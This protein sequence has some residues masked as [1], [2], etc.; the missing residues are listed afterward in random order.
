M[1]PKHTNNTRFATTSHLSMSCGP[2]PGR[3]P[4]FIKAVY[5]VGLHRPHVERHHSCARGGR[6]PGDG[7]C[8][9]RG[10]GSSPG[11][12]GQTATKPVTVPTFIEGCNAVE[13]R[14]PR[15]VFQQRAAQRRGGGH[16]L[17]RHDVH[18]LYRR[19]AKHPPQAHGG[20]VR[21]RG[22]RPH[23]R[24]RH[25]GDRR[26][27]ALHHQSRLRTRPTRSAWRWSFCKAKS[28]AP[29]IWAWT[30]SCCIPGA[31]TDKDVEY[32]IDR[33]AEGLDEVLSVNGRRQHRPGDDGGQRHRDRAHL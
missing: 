8:G 21:A 33:I 12:S 6:E 23:E 28:S 31:Y 13:D 14:I 9:D 20:A 27:R 15:F 10:R 5:H 26:A 18:D 30:T 24:A 25:R 16:Q 2:A 17:R 32:G 4:H 3:R 11:A 1:L 7:P 22:A 29:R 19:A